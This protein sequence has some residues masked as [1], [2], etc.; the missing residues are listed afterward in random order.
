ME[1]LLYVCRECCRSGPAAPGGGVGSLGRADGD[2]PRKVVGCEVLVLVLVLASGFSGDGVCLSVFVP[3]GSCVFG[4]KS[5]RTRRLSSTPPRGV[6]AL[7]P[8]P[9]VD[10]ARGPLVDVA[11]L[12]VLRAGCAALVGGWLRVGK[13]GEIYYINSRIIVTLP[14][15]YRAIGRDEHGD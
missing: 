9:R 5:A 15:I 12:D 7:L 2:I 3:S 1:Y 4:G 10:D 8:R 14:R 11:A 13:D 6:L